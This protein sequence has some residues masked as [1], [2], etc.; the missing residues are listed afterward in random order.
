[1]TLDTF[2]ILDEAELEIVDKHEKDKKAN[3]KKSR[4][5]I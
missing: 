4:V 3:E 1:L 5:D 2:L